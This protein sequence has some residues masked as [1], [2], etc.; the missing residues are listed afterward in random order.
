MR[1]KILF[2]FCSL[3]FTASL[4]AGTHREK[5]QETYSFE[6]GSELILDNTN[7]S[8]FIESWD[9]SEVRVEAE[10]IVKARSRRDAE[11]IMERVKIEVEQGRNY[12]EIRTKYPKRR[13]GFWDSVFGKG[14]SISVKYRI[15]VPNEA[16]MDIA[17]V[18]GKVGVTEV[19]GNIRVKTTNGSIEVY[20]AKGSV[21]AKTTNGGI[22]V[23]LLEFEEDEDMTFRTTN[24][25]IKVYF[26]EKLRADVEAKTTNGSVRTDFPIEIRGEVSKRRLKGKINGGGGKIVLHTTNGGIRILEQ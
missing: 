5:F 6:K 8:V 26:P 20:E 19:T 23:E 9:R 24:G 10:K 4:I 2:V 21:N 25:S 12:L 11:E 14:V 7:G 13:G 15:L 3:F 22:N 16:N 1:T 17:T 18:N